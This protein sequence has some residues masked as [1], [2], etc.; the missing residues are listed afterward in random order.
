MEHEN[1]YKVY[2]FAD[3]LFEQEKAEATL[4]FGFLWNTGIKDK[5]IQGTAADVSPAK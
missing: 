2:K 3:Y 4:L 5:G 1:A